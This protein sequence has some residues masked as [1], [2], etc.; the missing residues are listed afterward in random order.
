MEQAEKIRRAAAKAV[1]EPLPRPSRSW[2]DMAPEVA[3]L[4]P[5]TRDED[6][7]N[8][9]SDDDI[10][11][12]MAGARESLGTPYGIW[13]NDPVGFVRWGLNESVWSVQREVLD[14]LPTVKRTMV[15]AGFGLGK[16]HAAAYAACWFAC[17]HPVGTALTVT[18]ATRLRQVQRQLWPHVRR[19]HAKAGLPG[20][21]DMIQWKMPDINGVSTVVAYGFTA[22]EH[23]EAAMQGIHAP[24][25]LLIVDEA[26]GISRPVG[27]STRNLLTGD[28]RMLAI[29]NPAT[30][31][32]ASWFESACEDGFDPEIPGT[33]TVVIPATASPAI[34]GEPCT[35]LSCPPTV[36][37]HSLG[38][39]LVDPVLVDDAIREHGDDAPYVIAKVYAKFPKGGASRVIPAS[40]V[41]AATEAISITPWWDPADIPEQP[42][43][44]DRKNQPYEQQPY[45]GADIKLGVDVAADGG[46]EFVI[47]RLEGDICRIRLVQSGAANQNSTDVAGKIL[48]E[49]HA[50]EALRQALGSEQPVKVK[51]DAIGIGWG[52]VGTLEAWGSEGIHDA[53]IQRV[54]VSESPDKPADKK[55]MWRPHNKR[56]EMWLAGREAFQPD[57]T[58]GRVRVRLDVDN[59][60]AAQLRAPTYG[61]NASGNQVIESKEHMKDRGVSSPDR[62][63]AVL[64]A[65]YDIK[66]RRKPKVLA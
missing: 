13:V 31:D 52:V 22:P 12:L 45:W 20:E 38:D 8:R 3:L 56:A 17:V 28:A 29:G 59:R 2:R 63:E 43:S 25:V 7:L 57:L 60:T 23:D 41:D 18:T 66:Q 36:P 19:L 26:G 30:D 5:E 33:A 62:A 54:V 4:P 9:I 15:P 48:E 53:Q 42:V 49:I 39:H 58:S 47:A 50:A 44:M 10:D 14:T 24:K 16:T 37:T 55:A 6:I 35:C 11:Q 61:T 1:K 46:D 27:G 64:L 32:E 40:Y 51:V 65:I 21:C 34:T